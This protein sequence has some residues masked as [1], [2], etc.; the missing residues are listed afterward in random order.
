MEDHRTR[1]G[2]ECIARIDVVRGVALL[3]VA[4]RPVHEPAILVRL[5]ITDAKGGAR[6][7]ARRVDEPAA[8]RRGDRPQATT[9]TGGQASLFARAP[10]EC[11]DLVAPQILARVTGGVRGDVHDVAIGRE[12]D[13]RVRRLPASV[14]RKDLHTAAAVH[15][16]HPQR[17]VGE[18]V[19]CRRI[20]SEP[21]HD[22]VLPV[23]RPRGR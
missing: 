3:V 9:R 21:P 2:R 17:H 18:V 13:A 8:V 11:D 7:R 20:G 5:Q 15:V 4:L 23:R 1:I 16:I 14:G 19:L 10:I 6:T 22:E 12:R